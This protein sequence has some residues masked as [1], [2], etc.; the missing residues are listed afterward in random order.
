VNNN[1]S[2]F[3]GGI[4]IVWELICGGGVFAAEVWFNYLT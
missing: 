4:S 1:N 2:Y 3:L